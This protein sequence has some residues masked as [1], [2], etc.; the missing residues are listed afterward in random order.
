MKRTVYFDLLTI[1]ACFAVVSLHC[2]SLVHSFQPGIAWNTALFVEVTAYWAVPV[3]FMLTGANN[4]GYRKK[5]STKEFLRR[6]LKKLLIPFIAWTIF[7]YVLKHVVLVQPPQASIGGFVAAFLSNTI[8]PI[9]WF[10]F[11]II[12]LTLAMPVLSLLV[13]R[14]QVMKY[15]VCVGFFMYS[16]APYVCKLFD[17]VP[18]PTAFSLPVATGTVVY[19]LLG[20]LAATGE[21][22]RKYRLCVYAMAI[23]CLFLRYFY[24]FFASYREGQTVTTL[25]NYD[26]FFAVLLAFAVFLAFKHL[27]RASKVS[28]LLDKHSKSIATV[29]GCSFGVYLIHWILIENI[30]LGLLGVPLAGIP[31]QII[32]PFAAYFASLGIVYALKR[33]PV[34]SQVVP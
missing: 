27:S 9:Y 6:R 23:G 32:G 24:T 25:F 21:V 10:F 26:G 28:S 15:V 18:W 14:R 5:Y 12:G 13:E 22:S 29:S 16:I 19:A 33:V 20:Y 3:F 17:I 1:A 31:M 7:V 11:S 2:N 30:G 34:L 4:L 8:M